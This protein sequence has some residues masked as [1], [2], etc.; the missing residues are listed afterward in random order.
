MKHLFSDV[1][2]FMRDPLSFLVAKSESS[3][4][5]LISLALGFN[6]VFLVND[7]E[8]L[9]ATFKT[10]EELFD[11][12]GL[13]RKLEP[14]VWRDAPTWNGEAPQLRRPPLQEAL[15]RG[16]IEKLVP[17]MLGEIRR[18]AFQMLRQSSFDAHVFGANLASKLICAALFGHQAL[19]EADELA[20][21]E[22]VQSVEDDLSKE[23]F[24]ALPAMPWIRHRARK[25]RLRSSEVIGEIY[26]KVESEASEFSI[27]KELRRSGLSHEEVRAEI[28]AMLLAGH[29][30]MG[31]AIAWNMYF[32]AANK[33]LFSKIA[34]EADACLSLDG[35]IDQCKLKDAHI[36]AALGK[37]ILRL[38]PSSWWFAREVNIAHEVNGY[39]LRPKDS[40]LI[41]PWLFHRSSRYWKDPERFD[42]TRNYGSKAYI[43]F[44]AGSRARIGLG[45]ASLELQLITLDL[46]AAF[47][48]ELAEVP[49]NF[50][51][52]TMLTLKPPPIKLRLHIR[53]E[54]KLYNRARAKRA[55]ASDALVRRGIEMESRFT[56][57]TRSLLRRFERDDNW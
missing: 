14:I 47:E 12:R 36:S 45:L 55:A 37:E 49:P 34:Q 18:A 3:P 53:E 48:L 41:S 7:A 35:D 1:R 27:F 20:L 22:A 32:M 33:V 24:R 57:E 17:E 26:K 52:T 11:D 51:P 13:V 31:S 5:G 4:E 6:R 9:K 50:V 39:S 19:N 42:L 29:H 44:G 16:M 28:T 15:A 23:M 8:L 21:S 10:S 46:A 38:F 25:H 54:E 30:T 2:P 43:P 40:L 56:V